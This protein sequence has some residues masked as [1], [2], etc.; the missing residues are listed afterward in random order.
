VKIESEKENVAVITC[1]ENT[2]REKADVED[3]K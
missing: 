1:G 3:Y 2:V